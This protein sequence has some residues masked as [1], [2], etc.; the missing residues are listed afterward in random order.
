MIPILTVDRMR[1]IDL[2][3]IGQ[4]LNTGFSYMK[5]AAEGLFDVARKIVPTPRSGDIVIVCGKGNNGG[6]GLSLGKLL[7]DAGYNVMCYLLCEPDEL[8]RESKLAYEAYSDSQGNFLVLDDASDMVNLSNCSLIIDALIGIGLKGELKPLYAEV[9]E[10]IN[11]SKVP[12]LS[13]DTPSG[14]NNDTGETGSLCVKAN[15]TVT[16]GFPKIGQYFFPARKY[17]GDLYIKNLGY[18]QNIVTKNSLNI[19][20]PEFNDYKNMLPQRIPDGSKFEHGVVFMLSGSSGMS[21]SAT[22]ASNSSLRTG[23]GMVYLAVPKSIMN[24]IAN[25]VTEVVIK[26]INETSQG[27]P[28]LS[29]LNEITDLMEKSKA[30]CIGPGISHNNETSNLVLEIVSKSNIPIVLDADGINAFKGKKEQLK[31]HKSPVVITPHKGEWE[32]VFGEISPKPIEKIEQIRKVAVDFNISILFKGNPTIISD[33]KGNI[34]LSPYGNSGMATAGSGD[35]LSGIITSL[36][37]QGCSCHDAAILGAYIHAKAGE[38]ASKE[39]SEY[40]MIASDIVN[41]IYKVIKRLI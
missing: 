41:N 22:L 13:V 4:D 32:R 6:D 38:E 23:C 14:I 27:T 17:I 37:A 10:N 18:P 29:S 26:P 1:K 25:K 33:T 30:A 24:I 40:S 31:K 35:V 15:F 5:K 12:V 16:M 28:S 39:L 8:Q 19:F 20:L 34:Y 2:E 36:I 9:I 3:A 11:S 7:L 21:G